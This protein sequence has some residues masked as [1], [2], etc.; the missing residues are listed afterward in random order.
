MLL[1]FFQVLVTFTSGFLINR[2]GR[3]PMML[4]GIAIFSIALITAF[5]VTQ[6]LE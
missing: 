3:R 5:I 1:G 6:F 4:I 2:L